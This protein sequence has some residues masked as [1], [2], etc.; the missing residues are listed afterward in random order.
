MNNKLPFKNDP[1]D[2]DTQVFC[3]NRVVDP[4]FLEG[5][6]IKRLSDAYPER[7]IILQNVKPREYF[8][9]FEK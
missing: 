9:K 5:K 1:G 7:K 3:K 8:L 4:L 2:F 6:E